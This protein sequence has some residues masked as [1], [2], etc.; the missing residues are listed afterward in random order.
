MG[1]P[2]DFQAA[3]DF[4]RFFYRLTAAVADADQRPAFL[5]GGAFGHAAAAP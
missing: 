3:A 5:A 4:N 2:I 1:Q